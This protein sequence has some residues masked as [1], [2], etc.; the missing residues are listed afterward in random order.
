MD[1]SQVFSVSAAGMSLERLRLET[2]AA[3]IA[4]SNVRAGDPSRTYRAKK[5]V[6]EAIAPREFSGFLDGDEATRSL[7][8][9]S[10]VESSE[11]PRPIQDPGDPRADAS[12]FVYVSGINP[13]EEM[14]TVMTAIRAFEANVRVMETSRLMMV[15]ALDIGSGR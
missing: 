7:H 6:A 13:V 12:G 9:A 11:P 14:L 2:A 8:R 10:I 5:V 15:R 4:N 1:Y 3:N